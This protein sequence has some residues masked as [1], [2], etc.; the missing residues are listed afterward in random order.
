MTMSY[1]EF[2]EKYNIHT[3]TI[4]S[5]KWTLGGNHR[6]C[7]GGDYKVTPEAQPQSFEEFDKLIEKINPN[8]SFIQ[9][10]NIYN[11]SVSVENTSEGDWYGGCAYYGH[12]ECNVRE[13]Y[14]E[15]VE[16]ELI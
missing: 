13:L 7:W 10:K 15:L 1:K 16:R 14:N 12:Y 9:Y 5:C 4:T 3:D 8:I 6:D 11:T 2:K